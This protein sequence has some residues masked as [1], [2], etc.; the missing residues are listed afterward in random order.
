MTLGVLWISSTTFFFQVGGGSAGSVVASRLTE[1]PNIKVLLLE[2]GEDNKKW[3]ETN[4][5]GTFF[6][7]LSSAITWDHYTVPQNNRC[8]G[9]QN[10][11]SDFKVW[12]LCFKVWRFCLFPKYITVKQ[13]CHS[14]YDYISIYRKTTVVFIT[15]LW[16]LVYLMSLC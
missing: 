3:P 14:Y 15:V 6:G 10:N 2:A 5:P 7:M 1:D 13:V 12:N 4:V 11:V 8:L 16:F 9:M